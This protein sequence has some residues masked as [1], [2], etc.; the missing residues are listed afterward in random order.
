MRVGSSKDK[1]GPSSNRIFLNFTV[2]LFD[3]LQLPFRKPESFFG[4]ILC[5]GN[6]GIDTFEIRNFDIST[7]LHFLSL[8]FGDGSLCS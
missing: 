6:F 5:F 8:I 1:A 7:C 2:H 3:V 4:S